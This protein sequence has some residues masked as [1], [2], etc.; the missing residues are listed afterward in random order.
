MSKRIQKE[1]SSLNSLPPSSLP[2]QCTVQLAD[3][4]DIK[5]WV[6]NIIGPQ[7]SPYDGGVFQFSIHF[8]SDYP[9]HVP[10]VK[11]TTQLFHPNFKDG[12]HCLWFSDNLF[13]DP[14]KTIRD[15]LNTICRVL[16][17]PELEDS[18]MNVEAAELYKKD[19]PKYD[20]IAKQWTS[21]YAS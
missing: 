11:C 7:E 1:F 21:K 15:V 4:K 16:T 6:V 2:C 5:H 12:F 19:R 14:T 17:Q 8:P 3:G 9:F 10:K 20:E 13:W 18:V